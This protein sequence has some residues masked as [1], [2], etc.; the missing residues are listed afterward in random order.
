MSDASRRSAA[1]APT[2]VVDTAAHG[3]PGRDVDVAV[4]VRNV[5]DVPLDVHVHAVGLEPAWA[6]AA[7]TVPALA[8]DATASATLRV[9]PPAG[10]AAGGYP[11]L[12][13]VETAAGRTVTDAV[14]TLDVAGELVVSI[15]PA[16]ARGRGRRRV[17]VVLA[18]TGATPTSARLSATG[19]G[20]DVQVRLAAVDVPAAGT[21]RVPALLRS[22]QRWVGREQRHTYRVTATGRGA[23]QDVPGTFTARAW[24]G[25]TVLKVAAVVAVL[26]LWAGGA[27]VGIPRVVTALGDGQSV[28]AE[29]PAGDAPGD[30]PDGGPGGPQGD[31]QGDGQGDAQDGAAAPGADGPDAP[32]T[33]TLRVAGQVSGS[34]PAGASVQVVPTSELWGSTAEP[35]ATAT[36]PTTAALGRVSLGAALTAG[37]GRASA[38][39]AAATAVFQAL[40]RP[41]EAAPG[42]LLGTALT[43][44]GT[45]PTAQRLRTTTDAS[46]TW[47]FAGLSPTTRYLVTVAKPGYRTQRYVLTGAELSATP[48]QTE[49]RAGDG[50]L[51]GV[52]TGPDGPVGGVG[53]T[54]TDGTTTVTTRTVT[55]GRVGTWSVE[56][57]STPSTYLVTASS[58]RWGSTSQLV[59]LGAAGERTVNLSVEPG[60]ASLTGVALGTA[61]LGGVGGIGGLTVTATDGTVTRTATT[62]TGD[63]AGRFVLADL[64]APGTYTVTVDGPGYATVTRELAVT[65][66]GV[67]GW[68]V[69]MTAVGGAV[70]GTVRGDDGVGVTAAG[71]TLSDGTE[72]YKS[73]SSSD[74]NGSYRF[75]G[76]AAGTYVLS[77]EA[78][79]YVT[80]YAQVEVT[81]GG[82]VTSDLVLTA[83]PGDGLV[84][85]AGITGRVTDASTGARVQCLATTE[86]CLVTV[87]TTA[88]ALDGTTRTV[89]ATADPDDAYVLPA[90]GDGG[91]LPGRYTLS[92]SVPGYE[93]GTVA[94]TVPMGAVVEAATVALT[95]S[96]SLVGSVLPRVGALPPDVCVVARRA[97]STTTC[98]PATATCT[99]TDARCAPVTQ[100]MYELRR[101]PAGRWEVVV[102]GLPGDDWV[103]P[104]PVEVVLMPGETKRYDATIERLGIIRVTTL[105]ADATGAIEVTRGAPVRATQVAGTT[106]RT[107]VSDEHGVA[108]LRGLTPGTYTIVTSAP[109]DP[110]VS[111]T[112]ERD[113]S[114]NQQLDATVVLASPVGDQVVQV[115]V[116]SAHDAFQAREGARVTVTGVVG[117]SGTTQV[118]RSQT[119][120]T[121]A[122]GEA[123]VCTTPAG[124]CSGRPVLA[125]VSG[126]VDLVVQADG[127]DTL[128]LNGVELGAVDR[129]VLTPSYQVL[130]ASVVLVPRV[131]ALPG[132]TFEA[133]SAPPGTGTV[134]L[135]PAVTG[136][137]TTV[138]EAPDA[139]PATRV[140]L[141]FV[142]TVIGVENRIR[143]GTYRFAVRAPGWSTQTAA[144]EIVVEVPYRPSDTPATTRS[145]TV[146]LR[147]GGVRV[148]LSPDGAAPLAAARVTLSADGAVVA[149][150]DV[151]AAAVVDLGAVPVGTYEVQVVAAGFRTPAP[152]GVEVVAGTVATPS[153]PLAGLGRV[154]GTVSTR[155]GA[156]WTVALPG[157]DVRGEGPADA[158]GAT[159][160]TFTARSDT[161]GAFTLV[162]DLDR[163]GLWAGD[164]DVAASADAHTSATALA[165]VRTGTTTSHLELDPLGS[166]LT[167]RV[168]DAAGAPVTSGLNVRL[169][170][171]DH[172]VTIAPPT[173]EDDEFVFAGL[174]P[175]TYTLWVVPSTTEYT[176]VS[177]RVTV[178]PG[179]PGRVEV[180]LATP[181]GAVQGQVTQETAD[182]ASLELPGVVVTATPQGATEGVSVTTGPDGRYLLSGLGGGTYAL[183]FVASGVTIT[184]GVQVVPGQGTVLDV[185]FPLARHAVTVQ[186][187]SSIGAD[188]TGGLVTLTSGTG[189][190]LGPQPVARSGSRYVTTFAQ[191]PPG[192][193]AVRATGPAG[194][195]ATVEDTVQVTGPTTVPLQLREVELRLR[196]TGGAP[197]VV[198]RVTPTGGSA[199]DVPLIDGASDSVLYL[200]GTT[201]GP[202]AQLTATTSAG[203]QVALSQSTVPANATRLLV[204][205]TTTPAPAATT[206]SATTSAPVVVGTDL[207]VTVTVTTASGTPAGLV[208]VAVGSPPAWGTAVS[209]TLVGGTATL[210]LPTTGWSPGNTTLAVRYEPSATTWAPSST[211][212]NAQVQPVSADPTDPTDPAD[213]TAP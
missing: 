88:T 188:L 111:V 179:Q 27:L 113:I 101:L 82:S 166:T 20:V 141:T 210:T 100:G 61:V 5:A 99:G 28:A 163:E 64:P 190:V 89:T 136:T 35:A 16:D 33:P 75:V 191:V 60:V 120:T 74:G 77:A 182:G 71:L 124:A 25:P 172:A 98:V 15:E 185:T 106:V 165:T 162:G 39:A 186:L 105:R 200:P 108:E 157:A 170:Y 206:V 137:D 73:M 126:Q 148:T 160:V 145:E 69:A 116:Q 122:A 90:D 204:T 193:W 81:A 11:F 138:G 103:T 46:G 171:S 114:L 32:A 22:R 203:W 152:V 41:T 161:A 76:A 177:T 158:T 169:A 18:N 146:L 164:W 167:V 181:T 153:V 139:R 6:P 202:A 26:A 128:R 115:V 129:V 38:P 52:V 150:R 201:A 12:V 156:G 168:T 173:V 58:D 10:A 45:A 79:G 94:V 149:Q 84:A 8:P 1:T 86:P 192:T 51:R 131:A 209:A 176:T 30:G 175:L 59:T 112:V 211:T 31:G 53:L 70:S 48:L 80:G 205:A 44:E 118:R 109:D 23:P 96:P 7:V 121:D 144:S 72:T 123:L 194:H 95:P 43:V 66:A 55:E 125:L 14:L 197:S 19:S 65:P 155:L 151:S 212:V 178:G 143:P 154:H 87:T 199:L 102:A 21:V 29:G 159:D 92:V 36:L 49:L 4:R 37:L 9:T 56:G 187:T 213:P 68:E 13:V 135:T 63:D 17:D 208:R 117:Y 3:S 130:D 195:L 119:Y 127:F 140:A 142:D 24:L 42:K 189:A 2:V 174:L 34:D 207:T 183:T 47:A 107:A 78:F 93:S 50:V 134:R 85:T 40:A 147:D 184:R 180:P 132:V 54:L 104:D 110:R 196:A 57:L 91:L 198:V 133:V 62:L 67:E 97:G 83:V